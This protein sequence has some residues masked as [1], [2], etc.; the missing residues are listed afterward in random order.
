VFLRY[1]F[2]SPGDQPGGLTDYNAILL[3]FNY[4][5]FE[6]TNR[7]KFTL[8]TGYLLEPISRN[9]VPPSEALGFLPTVS[10]DKFFFRLQLQFGH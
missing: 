8:E 2:L 3:G 10:G 4:F 7:Y 5:P 9:I 1:D 6:Y